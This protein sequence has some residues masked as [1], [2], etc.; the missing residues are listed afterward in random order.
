MCIFLFYKV[1]H[2]HRQVLTTALAF[3]QGLILRCFDVETN[4]VYE[5]PE[6]FADRRVT[7]SFI[8]KWIARNYFQNRRVVY[9][10]G[11]DPDNFDLDNFQSETYVIDKVV[12]PS[13]DGTTTMQCYDPLIWTEKQKSKMPIKSLGELVAD[14]STSGAQS[15]QLTGTLEAGEYSTTGYILIDSEICGYT[16]TSD[17]PPTIDMNIT[18]FEWGTEEADHSAGALAQRCYTAEN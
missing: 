14:I 11:F 18:R 7:G 5:L 2:Q 3:G 8:G 4:D 16:V 6:E 13:Y 10:I 15:I 12:G 9:R 1:G 17:T